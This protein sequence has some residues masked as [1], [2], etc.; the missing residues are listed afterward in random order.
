[1]LPRFLTVA[2]I[3]IPTPVVDSVDLRRYLDVTVGRFRTPFGVVQRCDNVL[4]RYRYL[5]LPSALPLP[6]P[7]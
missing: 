7:C 3:S 2:G 4:V 6:P 1:M 5:I